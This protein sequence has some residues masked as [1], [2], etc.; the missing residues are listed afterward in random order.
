MEGYGEALAYEVA[1]FGID[2]TLVQPGNIRTDF[3]AS[4]RDVKPDLALEEDPYASAVRRAVELMAR[5]EQGGAP[6]SAVAAVIDKVL[7][8][9]RPPRRVTVGKLDERAGTF[10]KRLLPYRIFERAAKSSLGI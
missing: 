7:N 3:T 1:P 5:D 6:A 9:R 2:V 10:A 8:S 4:R